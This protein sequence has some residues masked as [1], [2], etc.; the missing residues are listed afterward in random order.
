MP[1]IRIR[2]RLA[3]YRALA[4]PSSSRLRALQSLVESSSNKMPEARAEFEPQI[5]QR[6]E[7]EQLGV[8]FARLQSYVCVM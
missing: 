4:E 7:L 6:A 8:R 1:S 3:N 5:L 2:A